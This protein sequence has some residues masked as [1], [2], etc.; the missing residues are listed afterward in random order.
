MD[1]SRIVVPLVCL[2]AGSVIGYCVG[3]I[4]SIKANR[5]EPCS[6]CPFAAEE[7]KE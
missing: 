5:F 3:L 4:S 1:W 7:V 2:Y 6:D